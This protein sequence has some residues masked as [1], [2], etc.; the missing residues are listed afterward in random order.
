LTWQ[1]L[2]TVIDLRSTVGSRF[3]DIVLH[4]IITSTGAAEDNEFTSAIA[5]R[6]GI[7]KPKLEAITAPEPP[8]KKS[9]AWLLSLLLL[10][11]IAFG[12]YMAFASTQTR[13]IVEFVSGSVIVEGAQLTEGDK[14]DHRPVVVEK[15]GTLKAKWENGH[16]ATIKGPANVVFHKNGISINNGQAWLKSNDYFKVGLTDGQITMS[17]DDE[18]VLETINN[19][20]AFGIYNGTPSYGKGRGDATP[21]KQGEAAIIGGESFE[22]KLFEPVPVEI[23]NDN[24]SGVLY[25]LDMGPPSSRLELTPRWTKKGNCIIICGNKIAQLDIPSGKP[26]IMIMPGEIVEYLQNKKIRHEISGVPL[27]NRKVEII[28]WPDQKTAII[29]E[30]LSDPVELPR[31]FIPS[32]LIVRDGAEISEIQIIHGPVKMKP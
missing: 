29:V 26:Y 22:W 23:K 19:R 2:G 15:E 28:K 3:Q 4:R 8:R 7:V 6:L 27:L 17:K 24:N 14:I 30:G 25:Q 32:T 13:A 20:S 16:K 11:I 21:I 31:S 9:K 10:P 5:S 1:T 18:I 12:I